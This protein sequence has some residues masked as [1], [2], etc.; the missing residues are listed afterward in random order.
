M[1]PLV[2][3][4]SRHFVLDGSPCILYNSGLRPSGGMA[5]AAVSKTVVERRASS[6]LASGTIRIQSPA[7]SGL[8][9]SEFPLARSQHTRSARNFPAC[10]YRGSDTEDFVSQRQRIP[11]WRDLRRRYAC[12]NIYMRGNSWQ[13]DPNPAKA[14]VSVHR[15]SHPE[16]KA[17]CA[18]HPLSHHAKFSRNQGMSSRTR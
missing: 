1:S 2:P 9:S 17:L 10:A 8:F 5:D 12:L 16:G 11:R 13:S 14:I 6:T 15:L 4:R 7:S 3:H 18:D